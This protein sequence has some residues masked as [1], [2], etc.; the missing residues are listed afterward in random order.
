MELIRVWIHTGP[1]R[2]TVGHHFPVYFQQSYCV[3][4]LEL[5]ISAIGTVHCIALADNP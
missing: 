2:R 1:Y 5:L 4:C 3:G